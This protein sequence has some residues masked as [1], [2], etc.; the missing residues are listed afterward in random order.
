MYLRSLFSERSELTFL[1]KHFT[2]FSE[3][4]TGL[5]DPF[6]F[7]KLIYFTIKSWTIYSFMSQFMVLCI[8]RRKLISWLVINITGICKR[9]FPAQKWKW[10]KPGAVWWGLWC[11]CGT[12][13]CAPHP[14]CEVWGDTL[15]FL[16]DFR[17]KPWQ[18]PAASGWRASCDSRLCQSAPLV[19]SSKSQVRV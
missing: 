5:H 9:P 3:V 1:L 19:G 2:K 14:S 17:N 16:P 10:P 11:S 6:D 15:A 12:Q 8:W 4:K 13:L 18:V 7:L